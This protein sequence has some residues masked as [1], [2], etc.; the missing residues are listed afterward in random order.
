VGFLFFHILRHRHTPVPG[1]L[2]EAQVIGIHQV[3]YLLLDGPGL[4]RDILFGEELLILIVVDLVVSDRAYFR[5]PAFLCGQQSGELL[6]LS[7]LGGTYFL[8]LFS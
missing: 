1:L 3:P 2:P 8:S 6:F 5:L 4:L 7:E